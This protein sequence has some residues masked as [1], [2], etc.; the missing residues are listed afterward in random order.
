[1]K[2]EC[3]ESEKRADGPQGNVGGKGKDKEEINQGNG[4]EG[5]GDKGSDIGLRSE[6]SHDGGDDANEEEQRGQSHSLLC[7]EKRDRKEENGSA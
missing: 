4:G 3:R 5:S 2:P 6:G 1:M 7:E